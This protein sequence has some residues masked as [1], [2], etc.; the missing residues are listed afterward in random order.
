MPDSGRSE[1]LPS[2]V[3]RGHRGAVSCEKGDFFSQKK[4]NPQPRVNAGS[5]PQPLGGSIRAKRGP[6][7]AQYIPATG[8]VMCRPGPRSQG[9]LWPLASGPRGLGSLGWWWWW[10]WV[11]GEGNRPRGSRPPGPRSLYARQQRAAGALSSYPA[12]GGDQSGSPGRARSTEQTI[13]APGRKIAFRVWSALPVTNG[14]SPFFLGRRRP[15]AICSWCPGLWGGGALSC[16]RAGP[17][18]N[19]VVVVVAVSSLAALGHS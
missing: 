16:C 11:G 3:S 8:C 9:P 10:W 5:P 18:S 1:F 14:P 2:R 4:T 17:T 15:S 19:G 6:A 13:Q 12:G 7:E